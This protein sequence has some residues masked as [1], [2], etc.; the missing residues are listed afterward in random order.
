MASEKSR[1]FALDLLKGAGCL[2]MIVAHSSLNI[3]GY[4]RF[5]FWGGL[6]PVLFFS[7][8]GVTASFQA[9]RHQPRAVI[10]SYIFL[11]LL[12][13]SFNRITDPGFLKEIQFDIIQMIAVGAC[14]I[15]L[16]EYYFHP[17]PWVYLPLGFL[18]FGAKFGLQ[19][20]L[21]GGIVYGISGIIVP[22]GI[23][24][25]FPWLFLFFM[26]LFAY[27]AANQFNLLLAFGFGGALA[28]LSWL[29]GPLDFETKWDM[30]PQYFLACNI[31]LFAG[32]FLA[33]I[34]PSAWL[35]ARN[36]VVFFGQNSL[37]FLY[38]HFP[39]V[40]YFKSIKLHRKVDVIFQHPWVFWA[41]V[42]LVTAII[43]LVL[44][45]IAKIKAV[46][47]P[48][49]Y[50]PTWLILTA[51]VFLVGFFAPNEELV[52]WFEI[53]LGLLFAMF[54]PSLAARLKQGKPSSAK[55]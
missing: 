35:N 19:Y 29:A 8:T 36:P 33:R 15:Y 40:L 53:G 14:A 45:R 2:L 7:V 48:F 20:L 17:R 1:D 47:K 25:V 46:S 6:A 9:A 54:Y 41:L 5:K 10:I 42:L 30:S 39:L 55:I 21:N 34:I 4:D 27:R 28:I 18:A 49:D 52:Y 22:P 38:V 11:L 37:L 16:L 31:L 23:F 43:M 32:F 12:G 44:I 13:F 51:L 24:P 3:Q 50:L 26:G